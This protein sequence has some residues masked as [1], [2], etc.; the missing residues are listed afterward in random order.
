[1]KIEDV[2]DGVMIGALLSV[3]LIVMLIFIYY[4]AID[5]IEWALN[6]YWDW[7]DLRKRNNHRVKCGLPKL[8]N[9]TK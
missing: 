8:K 3:V 5:F 6:K 1:M 2:L 9:K 7:S 4:K